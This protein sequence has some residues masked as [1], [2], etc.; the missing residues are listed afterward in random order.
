MIC[1]RRNRASTTSVLIHLLIVGLAILIPFK[2]SFACPTTTV[3]LIGNLN[4]N[5][6]QV[7]LPSSES[8]FDDLEAAADLSVDAQIFDS[9][10]N[11]HVLK[12][13]FFHTSPTSE[14]T[15]G[16]YARGDEVEFGVDGEPSM[17]LRATIAFDDGGAPIAAESLEF[18]PAWRNGAAQRLVFLNLTGMAESETISA[19]TTIDQNGS[20]R[21]CSPPAQVDFDGDR[22][23]EF[24]VFRPSLGLW[25]FLQTGSEVQ[26]VAVRQWG[27]PGDIPVAAD[28]SGDGKNDLTVWRPANGTWYVCKSDLAFDCSQPVIQQ[29]GLPGDKPLAADFD[30][31]GTADFA[32]WR[33]STGTYYYMSSLRGVPV[34]FQWGLA[35]DIPL[36][37]VAAK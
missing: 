12:V 35:G 33:P 9:F 20:S 2:D 30:G 14:W 6:P 4:A 28:F 36:G 19:L 10:D 16:V 13:Y 23:A 3:S 24:A 32:V 29:F 22:V 17:L 25:V 11:L 21:G 34:A 37:S 18:L 27:L 31:D 8:S 7:D 26:V 1:V 15:V 5:S